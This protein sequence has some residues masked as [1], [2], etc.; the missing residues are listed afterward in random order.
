VIPYPSLP[1]RLTGGIPRTAS[2]IL[3][4]GV[5]HLVGL[6]VLWGIRVRTLTAT[7]MVRTNGIRRK[8]GKLSGF[9]EHPIVVDEYGVIKP[10]LG[11]VFIHLTDDIMK[12]VGSLD[13]PN[14]QEILF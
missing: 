5:T 10:K 4:L 1:S 9:T 3:L 6:D 7:Q 13:A 2:F 8:L 12:N 11:V 14:L